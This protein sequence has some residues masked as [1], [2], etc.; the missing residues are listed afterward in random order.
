MKTI[1]SAIQKLVLLVLQ[2]SLLFTE[3]SAHGSSQLNFRHEHMSG[4]LEAFGKRG[5]TWKA[6][7]TCKIVCF[8]IAQSSDLIRCSAPELQTHW[9]Y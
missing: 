1:L 6:R 8:F 7:V 4:V 9:F 2:F 3:A 5:K